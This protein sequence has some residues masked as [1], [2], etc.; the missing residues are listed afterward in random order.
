MSDKK[1]QALVE[2][3]KRAAAGPAEQRLFRS[4][5]LDGL[6][7]GRGGTN[8]GAAARAVADGLLEVVRT[9]TKGKTA[10]EWVRLA[11]RGVD[12]L[13]EHESPVQ[14]LRDL[15][16]ALRATAEGVPLWLE[17]MRQKLR[18]LD[19]R[20][21]EDARTWGQALD[22]LR[23]RVEEALGRLESLAPRLPDGVVS[24]YPWAPAALEYLGRRENGG[25]PGGCPLPELFAA[26]ESRH[27]GLSLSAFHEGLRRMFAQGAL[28]LLP[29][30]EGDLAQPE[31]A[32]LDGSSV[33]YFA[34]R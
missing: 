15:R 24:A 22:G 23:R 20:L 6:F 32:L 16:D 21:A 8:A 11:P 5:K 30:A 4:G 12:F 13:H 33:L 28:R 17:E 25:V 10:V 27:A 26:L 2:A 18:A 31:Y 19:E 1:T 3:L 9:E 34:T 7:P 29:V 14:A